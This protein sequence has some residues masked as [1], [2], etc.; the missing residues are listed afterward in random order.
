MEYVVGIDVSK[1]EIHVCLKES[2]GKGKSITKSS[3]KLKNTPEGFKDLL[4]K[5]SKYSQSILFVMEATGSYYEDLAYYLYD[6]GMSVVVVLPN[7]IKHFA[8]SL[9]LKSKTDKIDASLIADYALSRELVCWKPMNKIYRQLRDMSRELL[10]IKKDMVRAKCQLHAMIHSHEKNN[11]VM[12]LKQKQIDFYEESISF[13]EENIKKLVETDQEFKERVDKLTTIKGVR[14]ITAVSILCE[15]N[16]F[17]L[18]SNARQVTSYAGLDVA[19]KESGTF[20]GKA[21]ISK[22]GNAR[23]RSILYMPALSA[24]F[25]NSKLRPVYERIAERNPTTKR[26]G[27]VAI[28]RK[29]LILMYILWKKNETFDPNHQWTSCKETKN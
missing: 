9:N 23:I 5:Y 17:E 20:K 15:T 8:K 25:H 10:S 28:M 22:R 16:G 14:L 2:L 27:I 1:D 12:S 26:K 13:L 11:C 24:S 4:Q 7:K 21:N 19:L 29:L 3:C 6:L 18:F